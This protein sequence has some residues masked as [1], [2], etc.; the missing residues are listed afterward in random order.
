MIEKRILTEQIDHRQILSIS[1]QKVRTMSE[2]ANAYADGSLKRKLDKL[3]AAL[4]VLV[5]NKTTDAVLL[6]LENEID[7]ARFMQ[8]AYKSGLDDKIGICLADGA[9][10][11]WAKRCAQQSRVAVKIVTFGD[12]TEAQNEKSG[13]GS[14][15]KSDEETTDVSMIQRPEGAERWN[16]ALLVAKDQESTP[17]N[18]KAHC[19]KPIQDADS[20]CT[21]VYC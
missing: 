9:D 6:L 10:A 3:I 15:A 12:V 8:L 13:G 14:S 18:V 5:R 7:F 19:I 21:V 2:N 20:K 11:E 1:Q 17:D 4:T 16:S